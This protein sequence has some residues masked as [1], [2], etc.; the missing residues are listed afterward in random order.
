M[1]KK[2]MGKAIYSLYFLAKA[3]KYF[4]TSRFLYN[5]L[6]DDNSVPNTKR[7]YTDQDYF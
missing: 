2:L 4:M 6:V 3:F 7:A 1:G 5:K